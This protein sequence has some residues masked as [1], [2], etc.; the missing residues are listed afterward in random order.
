MIEGHVFYVIITAAQKEYPVFSLAGDIPEQDVSDL[1]AFTP[2]LRSRA[3]KQIASA[4]P[5][6]S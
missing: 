5:H 2:G 3:V 4:L 1:P 6:H